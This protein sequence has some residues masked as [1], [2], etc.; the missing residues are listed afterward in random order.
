MTAVIIKFKPEFVSSLEPPSDD[1]GKAVE[2]IAVITLKR[3]IS[4]DIDAGTDEKTTENP[5]KRQ[6]TD[7]DSTS[8]AQS[9]NHHEANV[10]ETP[11]NITDEAS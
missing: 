3:P 10:N 9:T 7:S 5:S 11:S 8:S 6:K 4:E 1:P 2:E